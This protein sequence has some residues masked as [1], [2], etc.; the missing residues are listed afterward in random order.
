MMA[1]AE[2]HILTEEAP[3]MLST[4]IV[5]L[6]GSAFAARGIPY[7]T[8][9]ARSSDAKLVLVRVLAQRAPGGVLDDLEAIRAAL[10]LDAEAIRADGL[11]A[12][13]VVRRVRPVNADDV[14]RVIAEVAGEQR[15]ELIV[16]STHGRGGLG[17]WVYGSVADGVLQQSTTPV[18][19]VP[20]QADRPLPTDRRLRVLVPLDGS[21]LAEEAIE[22][23]DLL[24]GTLDAEL[25]LLRVVDLPPYPLNYAP[26][27]LD[28]ERDAA[29][30]YLQTHVERLDA[31][32]TTVAARATIGNPSW[33]VASVAHDIDADVVVMATNGR[34]GLARLVVGSVA[35]ATLRRAETPVLL[36][37]PAAVLDSDT[38]RSA[39]Q[40]P[41]A[42]AA[43]APAPIAA[44]VPTVAVRLSMADLELIE[45]GLKTLAYTP[46]YDDHVIPTLRALS[47]RL[48]GA[49]RRLEA[50]EQ[51]SLREP[52]TP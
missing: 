44:P 36:V 10:T 40:A 46:G 29:R 12:E 16:M 28:A 32:H 3:P 47:N 9:L 2:R 50:V 5:P 22:T 11:R 49:V 26:Y 4:I 6:D 38:P 33:M 15:A 30:E 25:T 1:S 41:D 23:A 7:A 27:D 8:A 42:A 51:A 45:R 39:G 13:A 43:P 35:T 14:A 31:Q 24:A 21:Q 17:R 52:A 19:L 20:P 48:D 18:L 34:T 37:R